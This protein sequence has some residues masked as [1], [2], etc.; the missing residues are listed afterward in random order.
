MCLRK[1]KKASIAQNPT[2]I[3]TAILPLFVHFLVNCEAENCSTTQTVKTSRSS[4]LPGPLHVPRSVSS[5]FPWKTYGSAI[6]MTL[7]YG[8]GISGDEIRFPHYHSKLTTHITY[9]ALNNQT[10]I[11]TTSCFNVVP[12]EHHW[13]T[14]TD[15]NMAT[16]G[17]LHIML[18]LQN[19]QNRTTSKSSTV[20][21]R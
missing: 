17:E 1:R 7:G 12:T 9:E 20:Q 5:F 6:S 14:V 16:S 10:T 13:Q 4:Q 3:K 21:N 2:H 11:V 15:T 8:L 18:C 19:K